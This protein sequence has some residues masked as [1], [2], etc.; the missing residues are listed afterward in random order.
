MGEVLVY[1]FGSIIAALVLITVIAMERI[2][3]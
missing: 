2:D 3:K 1:G